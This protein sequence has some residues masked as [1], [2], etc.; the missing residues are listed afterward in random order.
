MVKFFAQQFDCGSLSGISG[1]GSLLEENTLNDIK[2]AVQN[3][4]SQVSPW[5]IFRTAD[6]GNRCSPIM[7]VNFSE[8]K[9]VGLE[10]N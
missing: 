6:E 1:N 8:N 7:Y 4:P 9:W 2:A 10:E 3:Y 5:I